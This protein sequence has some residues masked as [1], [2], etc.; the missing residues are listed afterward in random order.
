M[1]EQ[2]APVRLIADFA[3]RERLVRNAAREGLLEMSRWD[4]ARNPLDLFDGGDQ[5]RAAVAAQFAAE[6]SRRRL[7]KISVA[8]QKALK[9]L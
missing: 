5:M 2:I 7:A 9:I 8:A 4:A 6:N 3:K 1:A